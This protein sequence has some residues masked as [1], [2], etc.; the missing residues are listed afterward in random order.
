MVNVE[1]RHDWQVTGGLIS[2]EE[3][4]RDSSIPTDDL[5][6]VVF[7]TFFAQAMI[8]YGDQPPHPHTK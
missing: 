1:M 2:F 8:R 5:S 7:R 4:S 6:P 3:H